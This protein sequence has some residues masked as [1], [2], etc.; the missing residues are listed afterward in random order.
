MEINEIKMDSEL[1]ETST[2]ISGKQFDDTL[3]SVIIPTKDRNEGL[4]EILDSLPHAMHKLKYETIF[5]I[6]VKKVLKS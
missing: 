6:A 5:C 1:P 4:E 3:I 2:L